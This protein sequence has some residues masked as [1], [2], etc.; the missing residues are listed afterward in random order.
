MTFS[1]APFW[2]QKKQAWS[3][4]IHHRW[5]RRGFILEAGEPLC[6]PW[7]CNR[8]TRAER[9]GRKNIL[10]IK[11]SRESPPRSTALSTSSPLP[12]VGTARPSRPQGS[13]WGKETG[14]TA[15]VRTTWVGAK[16]HTA[17]ATRGST[18]WPPSES[19]MN[20]FCWNCEETE[21]NWKLR[22]DV[23]R[24]LGDTWGDHQ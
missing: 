20:S 16:S 4:S 21:Q 3:P 1:Y 12:P 6:H 23:V 10:V 14:S 17:A 13:Y 9:T 15:A 18:M 11:G 5:Q 7:G 22:K 19:C 24:N 8:Y 2:S